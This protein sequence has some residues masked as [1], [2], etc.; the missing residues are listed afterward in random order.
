MSP[1]S[2]RAKNAPVPVPLPGTRS[3]SGGEKLLTSRD[4]FGDLVDS[5]GDD[6]ELPSQDPPVR[7]GPIRVQVSE[8]GR[9]PSSS[10]G[11]SGDV[12]LPA[13]VAALLDAAL[14]PTST[15][16]GAEEEL[17]AELP[18]PAEPT[19]PAPLDALRAN[20]T[21]LQRA[22]ETGGRRN[23]IDDH[24][25][26][27]QE[28][29]EGRAEPGSADEDRRVPAALASE[30]EPSALERAIEAD[31]RAAR[32]KAQPPRSPDGG[33]GVDLASVVERAF[34]GGEKHRPG[35]WKPNQA[36]G[37]YVLI[38]RV[39]VGGMAEVYRAKR[40]GVEGFEK[41]VAL[42]RILP[43]LSDN[44]EFVDMFINEA[45][46][47]AGLT[48][49]SIVQIYDLGRIERAYFI[50]MEYVHGRDLRTIQKRARERGM[51][52][53]LD[54]SLLVVSR[55]CAGLDY[56]HKKRDDD[57]RPMMIVHRD[58]S[59]QN[60]LISFEGEVKLTD[61]GIAKAV[62]KARSTDSG[63]LRGKLLYMS[64]EQAWGKPTDR[65]SDI[66]ALG[67]VFYEMITDQKPF[68]GGSEANVL[69]LVRECRIAPPTSLNP[70]ITDRIER[71]VM[72]ALDRDPE[73]RYQD[74]GEM[75]KDLDRVLHERQPPAASE[76]ARFMEI[77]FDEHERGAQR[78][79]AAGDS[80]EE[81]VSRLEMEFEA[82]AGGEKTGKMSGGEPRR[83]ETAVQQL[84][85]R[86]GLK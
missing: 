14:A 56:A 50:A 21:A 6:S 34:K 57:G 28:M 1:P 84:M 44:K 23:D 3:S 35:R 36:F 83:E 27:L 75:H 38:E 11:P 30:P 5:V 13:E 70:R 48:H 49:P 66:F 17:Q 60:I 39:A 65:R 42:K 20:R 73:N 72:R 7:R 69:E 78:T 16:G 8:P 52:F 77:L 45:K 53:P 63:T 79:A 25:D 46:M 67:L 32:F 43:H 71:V 29:L 86:L 26:A 59:P 41:V 10:P 4:L 54:L 76:L 31:R 18:P 55:V 37:P 22:A 61:F 82:S 9:P 51:R 85:R 33:D 68:L 80:A 74:A 64:P 40:T 24:L 62:T 58:V 47:V 2:R 19:M 81:V 12:L 15:P